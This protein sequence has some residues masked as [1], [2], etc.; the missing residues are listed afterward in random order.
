[1]TQLV[2]RTE[3]KDY[4]AIATNLS[5]RL[6]ASAIERD[7]EAGSP[8]EEVEQLR[9]SGLL[10]MMMPKA[11]GGIGATWMEGFTI[12]K[13]LAK[14][15]GS[16]GQL[17]ANQLAL[18]VVPLGI[19]TPA[20]A[21]YYTQATARHHLFWGNALNGRDARLKIEPEG[22]HYRVNGIKSF[23]TGLVAADLRIFGAMQAG[24]DHPIVFVLPKDREGVVYNQDWDNMGQRRTASGSF[25]FT[26]V[27]VYADEVLGPPPSPDSASGT[28]LFLIAQLS[29]TYVYLGIAEGA[30]EAAKDYTTTSTRPWIT[31]GVEQ[32]SKDPYIMHHYGEFWIQLKAAIALADQAAQQLQAAWEKGD[33]LT[34]A[35]RGEVAIAISVAKAFAARAGLD[36]TN[37]IFEVMGARATAAK[38]GFD[39]YWRD[40]RTFT[41]HDPV[42]YKIR[43]V[44]NWVLNQEVP[45][46][47]Q[48]S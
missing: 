8:L 29:K 45:M 34:F 11:Y 18:S 16:I 26:N 35:E 39:R 20:Q 38:Y 24:V 31:S 47:T 15:D 28:L 21:E 5:K 13:E 46:V 22:D 36:I 25:T 19:G 43:D 40:L 2:E 6:A 48:Y 30:F 42:D 7:R 33:A 44:G 14:A 17:Y 37:R 1:M 4:L 12:L 9:A 27:L 10:P 32:A 41:L 23:G 3:V